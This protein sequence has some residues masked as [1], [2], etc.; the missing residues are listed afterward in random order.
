M[1]KNRKISLVAVDEAHCISDWG[2]DFRPDY[3]RVGEF[4]KLLGSP[5]VI[6]LTATATPAVQ[7]DIVKQLGLDDEVKL[8]HEGIDRPN[9]SLQVEDVWD[10]DDKLKHLLDVFK[11]QEHHLGSGIVYFNT[12]QNTRSLQRTTQTKQY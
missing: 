1:I 3:T 2:H 4:I 11:R 8:F 7:K 12:N 5:R 10:E 6:A 9:L